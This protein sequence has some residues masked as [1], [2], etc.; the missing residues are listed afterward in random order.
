[1]SLKPVGSQQCEGQFYDQSCIHPD[2]VRK[3]NV[4]VAAKCTLT[5]HIHTQFHHMLAFQEDR[6]STATWFV[7]IACDL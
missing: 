2:N 3:W 1:M 4:C 5:K 6:N 7:Y